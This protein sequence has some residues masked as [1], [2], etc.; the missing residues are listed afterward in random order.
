MGDDFFSKKQ[1]L[2]M[3]VPSA[4]VP[5]EFNLLLNPRHK[6]FDLVKIASAEP[7]VYDQRLLQ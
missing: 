6:D 4:I 7:F 5:S 3:R 2:A 1:F